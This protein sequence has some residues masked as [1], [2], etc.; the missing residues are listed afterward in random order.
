MICHSWKVMFHAEYSSGQPLKML[1]DLR[2]VIEEALSHEAPKSGV[3]SGKVSGK[4]IAS[5]APAKARAAGAPAK[6]T[7]S[8]AS[9]P[10]FELT[11]HASHEDDPV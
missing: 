4:G 11:S 10:E 5:Q 2:I 7:T 3:T 6:F 9:T 8:N 1:A